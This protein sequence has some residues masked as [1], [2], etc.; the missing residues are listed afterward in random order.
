MK[1]KSTYIPARRK[2]RRVFVVARATADGGPWTVWSV[3]ESAGIKALHALQVHT[4]RSQRRAAQGVADR[5][6][7]QE[8]HV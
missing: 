4:A 3:P 7:G 6:N 2:E 1:R 8:A 5:L